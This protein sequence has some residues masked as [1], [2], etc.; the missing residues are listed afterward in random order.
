MPREQRPHRG[1]ERL[2]ELLETQ[3][4]DMPEIENLSI[5]LRELLDRF[6]ERTGREAVRLDMLS[7]GRPPS[8]ASATNVASSEGRA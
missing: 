2:G 5:G 6:P 8:P 1:V 7:A 3:S 4:A